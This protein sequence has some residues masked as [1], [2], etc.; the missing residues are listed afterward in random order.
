MPIGPDILAG[1]AAGMTADTFVK[2]KDH[3]GLRPDFHCFTP[4]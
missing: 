2:M 3:G 1:N 4:Q